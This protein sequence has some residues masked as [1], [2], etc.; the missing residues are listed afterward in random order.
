MG[1]KKKKNQHSL[2]S[3]PGFSAINFFL[4]MAFVFRVVRDDG[5]ENEDDPFLD[6]VLPSDLLSSL[7]ST[8]PLFLKTLL[9]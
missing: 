8:G 1:E 2:T 9:G 6:L 4:G 3:G 7:S 5:A